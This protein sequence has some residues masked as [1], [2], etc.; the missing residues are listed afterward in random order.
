MSDPSDKAIRV[1]LLEDD[2]SYIDTLRLVI[3][4]DPQ[5]VFVA[6]FRNPI[7]F[8]NAM[9]ELDVDVLLLDINLP[10]LTGIQCIE[11]FK[12]AKVRARVI[13]LTVEAKKETVMDAFLKGADG[14]LLKDSSPE[15]V[16]AA[17]REVCMDGAPMSPSIARLVVGML[18]RSDDS[19]VGTVAST[20][21]LQRL[22]A[23]EGEVLDWLARGLKYTEI[24]KRMGVSIDTVKTHV[25]SIY[26]KLEVRNRAEAMNHLL[27]ES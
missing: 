8:L 1:A 2:A 25:R 24:A 12:K 15:R 20:E 5:L 14:Y 17:V 9:E 21:A 10:K 7:R 18:K 16:G 11:A 4:T 22:T 6:A 3:D 27:S 13:M 19:A 26:Q 23:R